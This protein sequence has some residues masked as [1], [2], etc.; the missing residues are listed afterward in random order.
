MNN[1]QK[2]YLAQRVSEVEQS[3]RDRLGKSRKSTDTSWHRVLPLMESRDWRP[4]TREEILKSLE[5]SS[6]S[7]SNRDDSKIHANHFICDHERQ[8]AVEKEIIGEATL[9]NDG[10]GIM[11]AAVHT[12]ASLTRDR[13]LLGDAADAMN[14]LAGFSKY[15]DGLD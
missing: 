3:A 8:E 13:I 14:I 1:Q 9:Y 5:E 12:Q 6:K 7:Y 15:C 2:K 10:L 4:L 11:I